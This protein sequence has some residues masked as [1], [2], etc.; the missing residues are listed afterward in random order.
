[1]GF[2]LLGGLFIPGCT[3]PPEVWRIM[4]LGDSTSQGDARHDSYRRALWHLLQEE[5]Y[6]VDFV[7][8]QQE[9]YRGPAPHTDFDMDHEAHF[10][11]VHPNASGEQKIAKKWFDA[12]VPVLSS[13]T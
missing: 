7:G 9:P 3:R 8:S 5:G 11:G 2:I 13:S 10:D 6:P 1:M 4:P 12:L